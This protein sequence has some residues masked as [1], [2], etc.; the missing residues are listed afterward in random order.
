MSPVNAKLLSLIDDKLPEFIPELSQIVKKYSEIPRL[1]ALPVFGKF[2]FS[3]DCESFQEYQKQMKRERKV[4][5]HDSCWIKG[6][7]ENYEIVEVS[8]GGRQKNK[9]VTHLDLRNGLCIGYKKNRCWNF[10]VDTKVGSKTITKPIGPGVLFLKEVKKDEFSSL[11]IR[12]IDLKFFRTVSAN[13]INEMFRSDIRIPQLGCKDFGIDLCSS[14]DESDLESDMSESSDSESSCDSE[15]SDFESESD[16]D[17][18][19]PRKKQKV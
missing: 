1:F 12:K 19:P 13:E 9:K 3:Q 8:L 15:F 2:P 5:P 7:L 6:K 10:C 4:D 18:S 17:F 14:S 11:P 16:R